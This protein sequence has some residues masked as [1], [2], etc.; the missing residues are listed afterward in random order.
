MHPPN[1]SLRRPGL[2]R[3][4]FVQGML[5]GGAIAGLDLWRWPKLGLTA[6]PATPQLTGNNFDLVIREMPVNFTGKPAVATAVNGCVPAPT[7]HWREGDTVTIS[8]TNRLST[9]TSIHW[10]GLRVPADMDGVPGLSFAGIRP[11]QTFVYRFPVIQHGTYWYHSHSRFQEQTGHYGALIIDPGRKDGLEYDRDFV[12]LLSDW[13]DES[14]ETIFTNL[15]QQSD[16]YNYNQRTAGTFLNDA[17]RNGLGATVSDRLMWGRM[18]MTPTDLSDVSAATYTYLINGQPPAANWTALFRPRERVRLRFINGSSMTIF[19]VRI[20]NLPMTVVQTDGNDVDPV[21]VDEFRISVAETYDVIVAPREGS[22]FTIFAQSIDRTGFARATLAV[23]PGLTAAI[24][25]MDPRPLLTMV[26]MGMGSMQAMA[27]SSR[28]QMKDSSAMTAAHDTAGSADMSGMPGM[29]HH[30]AQAAR[31]QPAPFVVV[32]QQSRGKSRPPGQPGPGVIPIMAAPGAV[33]MPAP[34]SFDLRVGPQVDNVAM[35]PTQRLNEPGLGLNGNG[36]RVLTYAD[37]RARWRGLDLRPPAREIVLHLTGN[38]E[39]FI[40][41]FDGRK[42]SE[43]EPIRVSLGERVRIVLI[44]DSMMNHPIHL[45]GLWSELDN[46]KGD[47]RPYKHTINVKPG[48]RLSYLVSADTP[49]EWAY[50]CHLLYHMEAG[51]FRKVIVS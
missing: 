36:R 47:F 11:N 7:L 12:I 14:P 44:N 25:P 13:T 21:T 16:Y 27:D 19:D 39:R 38:M 26:D 2:S 32:P 29:H 40:W 15:K 33:E 23:R 22:A 4:R 17:A 30:G 9:D 5:A 3:R 50:H 43:A 35:D 46:G 49:G 18:N 24:P 6:A 41:G 31:P 34:K 28:M 45:H 48:E 8:V 20:P 37:L 1:D 10:H 42:F 51:M